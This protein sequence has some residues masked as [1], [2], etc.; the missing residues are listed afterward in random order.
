[1]NS[2]QAVVELAVV[3]AVVG[4]MWPFPCFGILVTDWPVEADGLE[5]MEE[6]SALSPMVPCFFL[7]N[8][9]VGKHT[10]SGRFLPLAVP[11]APQSGFLWGPLRPPGLDV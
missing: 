4:R 8:V 11:A 1:M 3:P 10:A 6:Q 9:L 7:R 2:P 5:N